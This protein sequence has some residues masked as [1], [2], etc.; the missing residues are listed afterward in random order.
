MTL[1]FRVNSILWTSF[2]Y[3]LLCRPLHY[4]KTLNNAFLYLN[5]L[6]I[7]D[8]GSIF[9]FESNDDVP[10]AWPGLLLVA[11]CFI[12]SASASVLFQAATS[13]LASYFGS[14]SPSASWA[15]WVSFYY[16]FSSI[17]KAV[18]LLKVFWDEKRIYSCQIYHRNYCS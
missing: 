3:T 6:F 13:F 16:S 10:D 12:I 9:V 11:F 2:L 8:F 4:V 14:N 15:S 7:N 17:N 1:T 18:G 5:P